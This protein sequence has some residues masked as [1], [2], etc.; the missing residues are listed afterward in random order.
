MSSQNRMN[1]LVSTHATAAWV[2]R[3]SRQATQDA[4]VRSLSL[5]PLV[6]LLPLPFPLG[7]GLEPVA[8][9]VFQEQDL[10]LQVGGEGCGRGHDA[11]S[12]AETA[13]SGIDP[14]GVQPEE[15]AGGGER[16]W[17]LVDDGALGAG[18]LRHKHPD[19]LRA[20]GR[21]VRP[22]AEH[23]QVAV[24]GQRGEF[25]EQDRTGALGCVGH[26]RVDR[27]LD[28]GQA[29]LD[30]CRQPGRVP[31]ALRRGVGG[32][33][34]VPGQ[35]HLGRL[36]PHGLDQHLGHVHD[37]GSEPVGHG[38]DG[39]VG[40][41]GVHAEGEERPGGRALRQPVPGPAAG[42]QLRPGRR[43]D[44][45][46]PGGQALGVGGPGGPAVAVLV[47]VVDQAEPGF[48]DQLVQP[49][50][51]GQRR[52]RREP[53]PDPVPDLMRGHGLAAA[54]PAERQ[55]HRVGQRQ[56]TVVQLVGAGQDGVLRQFRSQPQQPGVA[57]RGQ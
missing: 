39:A 55:R 31:A 42:D 9:V 15:L 22:P 51:V 41:V 19:R 8:Q 40:P 10:P 23:G 5:R 47:L 14:L 38:L 54:R 13:G 28:G 34:H 6:L 45:G 16:Q 33:D 32:L 7:I 50:P 49:G 2:I 57:Q 53:R 48:V 46:L 21:Q 37:Y 24:P 11:P 52:Q 27:R 1:T 29:A 3:S 20:A 36:G 56:V 30:Q 12:A 18:Q 25:G 17:A 44:R 26:G 43:G 4:A 35:A